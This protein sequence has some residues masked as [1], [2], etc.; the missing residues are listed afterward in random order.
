MPN[1]VMLVGL[2]G[3]GKSYIAHKLSK[4]DY[5]IHSSDD[6]REELSG[7]INNQEINQKVFNIL[8]N[9]VK[10]DLR[11]NKNCVYDATNISY[12]RRKA[13][14]EEIKSIENALNDTRNKIKKKDTK[15]NK[16]IFGPA[17]E[18]EN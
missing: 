6:I 14:L 3:S 16:N 11:A 4:M 18:N 8:H 12:K 7:D 17:E 2:P 13:F 9:R 10:E 15:T 1:F 5:N